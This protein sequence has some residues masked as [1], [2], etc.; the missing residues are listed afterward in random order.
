MLLVTFNGAGSQ[1]LGSKGDRW[2]GG[3]RKAR[4]PLAEKGGVKTHFTHLVLL[5]GHGE[6]GHPASWC[7]TH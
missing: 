2:G 4:R 6:A 3:S 7:N 1:A 5:L